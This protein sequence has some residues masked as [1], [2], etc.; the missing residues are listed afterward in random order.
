MRSLS[1]GASLCDGGQLP[2]TVTSA[3]AWQA[4]WNDSMS[5]G[6]TGGTIAAG[7]TSAVQPLDLAGCGTG[8]DANPLF[9]VAN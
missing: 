4:C 5:A 7:R 9:P 2:C 6:L 1:N 3:T 8:P